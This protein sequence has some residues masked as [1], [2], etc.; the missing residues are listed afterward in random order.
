MEKFKA[1]IHVRLKTGILDPQGQAISH[2]LQALGFNTFEEVRIGKLID[3][4]IQGI[5]EKSVREQIE[6]ACKR[7]LANPVIEDYEYELQNQNG[8]VA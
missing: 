1:K 8:Q 3:C 4:A 5:D 6:N 2:A 7:L